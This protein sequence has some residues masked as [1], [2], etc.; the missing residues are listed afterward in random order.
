M[1]GGF[2]ANS[3]RYIPHNEREFKMFTIR[4]TVEG[5]K[6]GH[7]YFEKVNEEKT[8]SVLK[9]DIP[10]NAE[11]IFSALGEDVIRRLALAQ[12]KIKMR[13]PG[14]ELVEA[15]DTLENVAKAIVGADYSSEGRARMS[16]AEKAVRKIFAAKFEGNPEAYE[17]TCV[18]ASKAGWDKVLEK[19]TSVKF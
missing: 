6:T 4:T 19:L 1:Q 11:E 12:L 5:D 14:V 2:P 17:E 18:R 7:V 3:L 9:A 10:V 16:D 15:G 13:A 8:A